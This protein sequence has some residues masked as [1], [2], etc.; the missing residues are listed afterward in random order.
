MSADVKSIYAGSTH[1]L[2][3]FE[4]ASIVIDTI[5]GI[6]VFVGNVYD[7]NDQM[8]LNTFFDQLYQGC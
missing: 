6:L 8:A 5:V 7:D 3:N 1:K 4:I 2:C